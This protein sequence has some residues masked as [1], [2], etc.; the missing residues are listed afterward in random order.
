V[1]TTG[2]ATRDQDL[3]IARRAADGD[4]GAQRELF[5]AQRRSVHHTLYRILGSN[6]DIEDLV[7]DAFIEIFRALPSFRGDS[8][9]G[10]WCQTITTRIAYLAISRRKPATIE[11][12]LVEDFVADGTPDAHRVAHAREAARRLYAA[13]DHLDP[14][15]RVAFA[16]AVIDGL[17]LRDVAELTGTTTFA[18]K[19]RV[20]RGR[21]ELYKRAQNDP[22][23]RDY[24]GALDGG[25]R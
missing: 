20:W 23:L 10:R 25:V 2:T 1:G 8:S 16:L 9:L 22:V 15:K 4:R 13:L 24:L 17:S 6:R 11:L 12:A 21:R 3:A 19:T 14:H 5:M 7:Q 18:V